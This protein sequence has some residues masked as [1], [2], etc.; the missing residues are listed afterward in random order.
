MIH[1]S[2]SPFARSQPG[3]RIREGA[4]PLLRPTREDIAGFPE[5]SKKLIRRFREGQVPLLEKGKYAQQLTLAMVS[6][7]QRKVE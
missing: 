7:C 6:R 3:L 5:E 2:P 1:R 4:P